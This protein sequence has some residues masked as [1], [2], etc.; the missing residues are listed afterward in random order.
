MKKVTFIPLCILIIGCAYLSGSKPNPTYLVNVP[1]LAQFLPPTE[2]KEIKKIPAAQEEACQLFEKIFQFD[3]ELAIELGRIPEFQD[4][5][6]KR[7][8]FA[9]ETFVSFLK[10]STDNEKR[11]LKEILSVGKPEYR[12]FCS[13][14]QGLFWLAEEGKLSEEKNPLINYSLR[15]LLDQAWRFEVKYTKEEAINIIR[16]LRDKANAERILNEC[17]GDV[18]RL[19][20]YVNIY[21]KSKYL[22]RDFFEDR[23][24]F[25]KYKGIDKWADFNV[26]IDRLNSPELIDCYQR[27]NFTYDYDRFYKAVKSKRD[28][29]EYGY[30]MRYLFY[31]KRG[32][33]T[34]FA[35][36]THYC[37]KRSGYSAQVLRVIPRTGP[38]W[39][40]ELVVFKDKGKTYVLD[41]GT[42]FPRGIYE[43]KEPI[44]FFP[45]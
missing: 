36:F 16:N 27:K 28:T 13:P 26:V 3:Q 25:K 43:L 30:D 7:E 11:A 19:N 18:K 8:I 17:E 34:D 5:V 22:T 6:N 21:Y 14:L 1:S 40:H 4:G 37:L 24:I 9:L 42:G 31:N 23:N 10:V 20:Y 33:C 35:L 39:W 29:E 44:V 32:V 12:K 45:E 41:N 38:A 15:N 2:T